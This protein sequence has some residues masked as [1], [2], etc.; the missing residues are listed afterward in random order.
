MNDEEYRKLMDE[1]YTCLYCGKSTLKS[2]KGIFCNDE[3]KKLWEALQEKRIREGRCYKCGDF[4]NI[5]E[6]G[7]LKTDKAKIC[8]DCLRKLQQRQSRTVQYFKE[9][10]KNV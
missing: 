10:R 6:M 9:I 7:N 8:M 5:G 2:S 3:H 4:E 1:I